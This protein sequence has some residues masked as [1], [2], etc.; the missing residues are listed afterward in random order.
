MLARF[1]GFQHQFLGDAGAADQFDH[2]V[3]V[4]IV[5]H[6]ECIV[7]DFN[8]L[9]C[10]FARTLGVQV[11]DHF[12]LDRATGAAADFFCITFEDGGSTAAYR[13]DAQQAYIDRFH[14]DVSSTQKSC[15]NENEV[16][17]KPSRK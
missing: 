13:A 14:G 6:V 2:D 4:R 9:A 7:G 17:T 12:Q 3:D 1:D 16:I 5:D 11:G 15:L 8:A 10:H